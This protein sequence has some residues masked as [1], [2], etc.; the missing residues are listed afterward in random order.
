MTGRLDMALVNDVQEVARVIDRLEEFGA[1]NGIPTE[2]S[3][4]FGMALDELITNI[5]SYGLK[6]RRDGTITLAI[7]H[8][9]GVL[10]AEL[11]DDGPPFDPLATNT[12]PPQGDIE[13]REVGGLGLT[14]VKSFM[15]RLDYRRVDGF[16]RLTMEMKLK[17]A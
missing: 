4:R 8:R 5:V 12:V 10:H 11:A 15:D 7:E 3:L 14:L 1:A 2:Q 17:A 16:N 9:D 13:T 6:D